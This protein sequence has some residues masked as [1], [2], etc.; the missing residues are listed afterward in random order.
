MK[1]QRTAKWPRFHQ[2]YHFWSSCGSHLKRLRFVCSPAVCVVTFL[3]ISLF[4]INASAATFVVNAQ[5]D[6]QDIIPGNG[7]CETASGNGVCT[8]RAAISEA[9][10][11]AGADIITLP[12]GTYTQTLVAANE[13]ANAGGD[14]DITS[15][16][17]II[18]DAAETTIV[19]AHPVAQTANERVFHVLTG[20]TAVTLD[21]IT[22]RNGVNRASSA[23]GGG[24]IR[25]DGAAANFTLNNS[26]VTNN[27]SESRGGGIAVNKGN[28][29]INNSVITNNQAGCN[30]AGTAAAGGGIVIDSEDNVAVSGQTASITNTVVSN[31]RAESSVS[32]TYG[33]G[34]FIRAINAQ[35]TLSGCTINNN[36]S[37]TTS[38]LYS[39]YTGGIYNQEARVTLLNSTVSGNTAGRYFA[40]IRNI[41]SSKGPAAFDIIN[42]TVSNNTAPHENA[43]GGGIGNIPSSVH[44]ATM[45]IDRSTI[46]GNSLPGGASIGGGIVNSSAAAGIATVN[47]TNSTIS[48]NSAHAGAG[49][50]TT[51]KT[52]VFN[53]NF[54]T[55]TSNSAVTEGGGFFRN[56][57][58]VTRL[59]NSILADNSVTS[60]EGIDIDGAVVSG[61]YNHIEHS[62]DQYF[63]AAHDVMD[64]DLVM[65]ALTNN[66]G[67][68][69][70]Q[71]PGAMVRNT[72]PI[73]TNGCGSPVNNDQRGFVRPVGTG[74]D[75]GSLE[76][77]GVDGT[78]T[79]TPT[80]APSNTPTSTPF[81][82]A[83]NTAT[84]TQTATHTFTPTPTSTVTATQTLTPTATLT[85]TS[86]PTS[87]FTPTPTATQTFTPTATATE[88][89]TPT[90]TATQTFTPT[91]TVT[92]THTPTSTS[93]QTFTPTSTVTSTL[94]PTPTVTQ[95]FTPSASATQTLTPTATTTQTFTQ[96]PTATQT[97]TPTP[98]STSTFTAT[99]TATFSSTPTGTSTSA[100][101]STQTNTPTAT[102]TALG[103]SVSLPSISSPPGLVV[104]PITVGDLTGQ[105]VLSFDLNVD[106][107]PAVIQPA[108]PPIDQLGTLSSAMSITPNASDP[109]HLI[110]SAFQGNP[111]AGSGTLINLRFNV[112]GSTGQSAALAF[113]NYTDS[114]NVFHPAFMF[115]EGEPAASTTNGSVTVTT[116]TSGS[117]SGVVTY[118]NA[119]GIPA[120][121]Y[122][123]SVMVRS[124]IGSPAV[125]A[126]TDALGVFVVSGFGPGAY[127]LSP[128]RDDDNSG[129][130]TAFDAALIARH[131]IGVQRITGY[132]LA[133]AD[134][135]G[136]GD[137][138]SFDAG[139]IASFVNASPFP[140]GLTSSWRFI[141]EN[142]TYPS[143]VGNISGE[144]FTALLMGDV[145]GSWGVSAPRPI[146]SPQLAMGSILENAT[147][148]LPDL[149]AE[150]GREIVV[151]LTVTG[152]VNK[153]VIS[154]EFELNY[155]PDVIQPLP[156]PT[157]ISGTAS[158][159]LTVDVNS[160]KLGV[161]RV[162]V[163]GALPINESGV[164]INLRFTS[165]GSPGSISLLSFER[166]MFNE[167]VP[168]VSTKVGRVELF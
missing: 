40:G 149:T 98:F 11:L 18:G 157:L 117:I 50:Y 125:S 116:G 78:P 130:I 39:A 1:H 87:T 126:M 17:T 108:S 41:A 136:N 69:L 135:S 122:V 141:P 60:G 115:N 80:I 26:T 79:T 131:V 68:T 168:K 14:F 83:T 24:G 114:N 46:S 74:C 96:T 52:T 84:P 151:P 75:K 105:Q 67:T 53:V 19:Q 6:A 76:F 165:V 155:D 148:E 119:V 31:N 63:P 62:C 85:S 127:T 29:T 145:S 66:G 32:N 86:T 103:I 112:I 65:S 94:T 23:I 139:L 166:I 49:I 88:T 3:T 82:T 70:T 4:S 2:I 100:A 90:A 22:I 89:F 146:E 38:S 73:G 51:G 54:S 109:G 107:D 81:N 7:I 58:G 20:G 77:E 150:I 91:A 92:S 93:T 124:T 102:P 28:L 64:V 5:N 162:A 99:P 104:I 167:G 42:S 8:L 120:T 156:E 110:V 35:I 123:N 137:V 56:A 72:I 152:V 34:I 47:V 16:I 44:N 15:P 36:I 164:L 33:G 153:N 25:I 134:V 158:R 144:N 59:S 97:F 161:L 121:R 57:S 140:N 128:V 163:F 118:G 71:I 154:Y 13:N 106:F 132:P 12:A 10:G 111:L 43:L 61:D 55:I 9:N 27:F 143:V 133:V 101:T 48:G 142:K 113:A 30:A 129:A 138:N 37:N 147:V 95:T 45:N 21:R 159:G 160:S